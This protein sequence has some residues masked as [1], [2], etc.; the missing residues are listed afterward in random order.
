MNLRL[1]RSEKALHDS[2]ATNTK[3]DPTEKSLFRE[4]RALYELQQLEPCAEKLTLLLERYPNNS[5]AK[6]EMQKVSTRLK[7]QNTGEY[8]F[9]QMY[10]Q[11]R[12]TP[13]NVDASS[14]CKYVEIR[15]STDR[16]RGLFTTR[17]V[18]AGDLLFCEKAF[19]YS[20]CSEDQGKTSHP[21][22]MNYQTMKA[23][24]GGQAGLLLQLVQRLYHNPDSSRAFTALYHGDYAAQ[25]QNLQVDSVPVVDSYVISPTNL[26]KPLLIAR[27]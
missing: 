8:N 26:K 13:P 6:T 14:F 27:Q 18:A 24:A 5:D 4:A 12:V 19:A 15:N 10:K 16:G 2:I 17:R 7:E 20:Y 23:F 1:G 22:L 9:A 3:I 21:I 11:A 25:V